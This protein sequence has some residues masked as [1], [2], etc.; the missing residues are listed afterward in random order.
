MTLGFPQA[1]PNEHKTKPTQVQGEQPLP[2]RT[3]LNPLQSKRIVFGVS[4]PYY[5]QRP[6]NKQ[7]VI[8]HAKKQKYIIIHRRGGEK[9]VC[10]NWPR[11]AQMLNISD[12]DFKATI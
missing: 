9:A 7:N 4:I 1:C 10:R 6:A 8:R 5:L 3:K 11:M 12:R 2:A